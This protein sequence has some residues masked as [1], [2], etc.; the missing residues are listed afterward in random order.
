[1]VRDRWRPKC[2][3]IRSSHRKGRVGDGQGTGTFQDLYG[4]SRFTKYSLE[5]RLHFCE[6]VWGSGFWSS[7]VKSLVVLVFFVFG[8]RFRVGSVLGVQELLTGYATYL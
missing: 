6:V 1:M 7:R 2:S 8:L 5:F 4:E 3:V